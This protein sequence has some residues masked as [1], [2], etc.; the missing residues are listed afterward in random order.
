MLLAEHDPQTCAVLSESLRAAGCRVL[1]AVNGREALES[2]RRE[3]PD[4]VVLDW[5]L[6]GIDGRAVCRSLRDDPGTATLP[7]VLLT[8]F[9]SR[10]SCSQRIAAFET[11]A[12]DSLTK[13]CN[14]REFVL[15]VEAVL[16]RTCWTAKGGENAQEFSGE[17]LLVVLGPL[18]MDRLR[19]AVTLDGQ[20]LTLTPKE[21]HLL[22]LL[23]G[24]RGL[25]VSSHRLLR[26]VWKFSGP[27]SQTRT[28]AAHVARLRKKLGEHAAMIVTNNNGAYRLSALNA[29]GSA[30][31]QQLA[32]A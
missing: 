18:Q 25:P 11:G 8:G 1:V 6:P 26:E 30:G 16:R 20:L 10:R 28:L 4:L 9:R 22:D 19:R 7:I 5:T 27:A 23:A 12:D 21:Y 32:A 17:K 14:P 2:T 3:K 24:A 15:R 13:P 31:T 29:V